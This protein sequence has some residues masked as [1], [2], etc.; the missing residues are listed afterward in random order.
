MS[1]ELDPRF[2]AGLSGMIALL[3]PIREAWKVLDAGLSGMIAL[4]WPIRVTWKV[5]EA[6]LSGMMTVLL[7]GSRGTDALRTG[8]NQG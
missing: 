1:F 4:L 6:E 8:V 5:L 7:T 2:F 3:W